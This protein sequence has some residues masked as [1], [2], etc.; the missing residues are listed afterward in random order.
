MIAI[1][2]YH[3]HAIVVLATCSVLDPVLLAPT[4]SRSGG[5]NRMCSSYCLN[6]ITE[7]QF[8]PFAD[9]KHAVHALH[10]MYI[11]LTFAA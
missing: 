1:V 6:S 11:M 5:E 4:P 7:Y 2:E 10:T 3:T 9:I 8:Y